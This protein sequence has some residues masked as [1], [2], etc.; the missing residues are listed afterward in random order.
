MNSNF[1]DHV[2]FTYNKCSGVFFA[3]VI[4]FKTNH[5]CIEILYKDTEFDQMKVFSRSKHLYR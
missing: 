3:I 1:Q 5:F 4:G 2:I